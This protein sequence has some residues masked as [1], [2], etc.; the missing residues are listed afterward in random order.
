MAKQSTARR[1]PKRR[2][3]AKRSARAPKRA[4]RSF[5]F[6]GFPGFIGARL[7]P[8]LLE[9]DPTMTLECLVQEKFHG[10]ALDAVELMD[11]VA[12]GTKD[13]VSLVIGDITAPGL[14]LG[15]SEARE[16][17]SRLAGAFHLAA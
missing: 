8:R 2:A 15:E 14:G 11:A 1:A 4:A 5:L 3:P 17:R 9:L 13:R 16:L 10:N 6:T 12:P 7:I